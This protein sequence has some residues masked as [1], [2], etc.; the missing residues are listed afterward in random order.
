MPIISTI[1]CRCIHT[2]IYIFSYDSHLDHIENINKKP[3]DHTSTT[4]K[5]DPLIYQYQC[6]GHQLTPKL[7]QITDEITQKSIVFF[8]ATLR[9]RF[10]ISIYY[11]N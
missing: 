9:T 11:N 4:L 8:S 2:V 10:P 7:K 6:I 1:K 5:T 3:T